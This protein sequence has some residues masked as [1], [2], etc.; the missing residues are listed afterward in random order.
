MNLPVFTPEPLTFTSAVL[1]G[2]DPSRRAY[3]CEHKSRKFTINIDGN[4][5]TIREYVE[6]DGAFIRSTVTK[7]KADRITK[8]QQL[9]ERITNKL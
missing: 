9:V 6:W 8:A 4:V 5:I 7:A 1:N 3:R 2:R